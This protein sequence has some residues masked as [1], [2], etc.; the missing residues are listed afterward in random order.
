MKAIDKFK[1]IARYENVGAGHHTHVIVSTN[2][3]YVLE[4][5]IKGNP[6]VAKMEAMPGRTFRDVLV[7]T[8]TPGE[9]LK[10]IKA[11]S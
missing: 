6:F 8:L 2:Y 4:Y 9:A 11:N 5:P 1:K 3:D 10:D 7:K